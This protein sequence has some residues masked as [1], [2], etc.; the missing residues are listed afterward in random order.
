V[1]RAPFDIDASRVR[2]FAAFLYA[3]TLGNP[4]FVEEMLKTLIQRGR[5]R[6]VDNRWVGWEVED[7]DVPA[8]IREVILERVDTLSPARGIADL[9]SVVGSRVSHDLLRDTSSVGPPPFC[10]PG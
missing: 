10:R 2:D 1:A 9:A 6:R 3:R 4:F 5:L 8:T 7:I